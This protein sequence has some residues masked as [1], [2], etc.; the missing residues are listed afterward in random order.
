LTEFDAKKELTV[1][2]YEKE[3][4]MKE[5]ILEIIL[6]STG[7]LMSVFMIWICFA[8]KRKRRN[9]EQRQ[10]LQRLEASLNENI[11]ND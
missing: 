9:D 7:S 2:E 3:L 11:N 1:E 8:I 6:M 4:E 5:K 10:T